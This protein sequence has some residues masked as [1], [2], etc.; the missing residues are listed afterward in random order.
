MD[1]GSSSLSIEFNN[2]L[3]MK[4]WFFWLVV[5]IAFLIMSTSNQTVKSMNGG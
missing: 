2:N 4:T 5:L 3:F 1:V